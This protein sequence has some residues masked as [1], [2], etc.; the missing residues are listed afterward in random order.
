MSGQLINLTPQLYTYLQRVSLREPEVLQK[1]RKKTHERLSNAHM[2]ISP[3]QGQFMALLMNLIQ[4]KKTLEIGT[5]TGYSALAVA[6]SLP[7]DGRLVA[8]DV[9]TEWTDIGRPFWEEAGV[10]HK[11]DLRIAPAKDTLQALIEA[12]EAG[13]FDFVFID[14]DKAGYSDYY[15]LALTLVR[16][17][18]LIAVDNVLWGG[19]VADTAVNNNQ[20]RCIRALNEKV[21]QDERVM[22]SMLPIGD[23]LTLVV[24]Q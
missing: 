9:S 16:K 24:K 21:Y 20:T 13:T 18:G 11:I 23:G 12:G 15:E 1:L 6:L 14:A 5:F 2:Q 17:G 22:M 3:E 19:D 4:A 8:C 10:A 7:N